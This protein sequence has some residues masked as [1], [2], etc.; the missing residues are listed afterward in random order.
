MMISPGAA[1]FS[2]PLAAQPI[3]IPVSPH[4]IAEQGVVG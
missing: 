4:Q 3:T 2:G 1:L